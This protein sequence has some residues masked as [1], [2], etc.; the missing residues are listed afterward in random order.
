MKLEPLL[1]DKEKS[2]YDRINKRIDLMKK[3]ADTCDPRIVKAARE[4]LGISNDALRN[5]KMNTMD[6]L[7]FEVKASEYTEKFI[8]ECGC[9]KVADL[10]KLRKKSVYPFSP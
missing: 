3:F 9:L 6:I 5:D 4:V 7:Q 8:N 10:I 1:Q 2:H